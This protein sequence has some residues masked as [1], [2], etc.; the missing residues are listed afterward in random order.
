MCLK[1]TKMHYATGYSPELW[2]G[3]ELTGIKLLHLWTK[4]ATGSP[5]LPAALSRTLSSPGPEAPR[6]EVA[7]SEWYFE[8]LKLSK[9]QG[10][11]M[12]AKKAAY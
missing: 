5:L 8:A 4:S 1:C 2:P 3:S 11:R 12:E 7:N 10:K 9:E 6:L